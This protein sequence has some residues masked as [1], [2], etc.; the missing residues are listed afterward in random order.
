MSENDEY[1]EYKKAVVD[2]FNSGELSADEART[3]IEKSMTGIS[4]ASQKT[5]VEDLPS[6]IAKGLDSSKY[7]TSG[8]KIKNLV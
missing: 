3:L 5:F 7:E 1:E 6:D 2:A 8:Q 4:T